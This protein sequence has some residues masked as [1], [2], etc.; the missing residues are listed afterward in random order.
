V[1]PGAEVAHIGDAGHSGYF[2]RPAEFNRIVGAFL[3]KT[4]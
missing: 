3:E 4:R 1:V 2:E